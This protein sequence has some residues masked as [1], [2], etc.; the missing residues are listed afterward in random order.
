MLYN[1]DNGDEW[2][3]WHAGLDMSQSN[4]TGLDGAGTWVRIDVGA[5]QTRYTCQSAGLYR[6]NGADNVPGV[7]GFISGTGMPAKGPKAWGTRGAKVPLGIGLVRKGEVDQGVINHAIAWAYHGP[8]PEYVAPAQNSD[9]GNFGGVMGLDLPE[10][11]RIRLNPTFDLTRF[12]AGTARIVGRA[13]QDYGAILVD[14]SGFPKCYLE[15]SN[16]AGWSDVTANMLSAA[17]LSEYQV[18]DWRA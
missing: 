3:I 11:T 5:G 17:S 12:P 15:S 14:N 4:F 9:G 8:S 2:N 10:G 6:V 18:I 13:L 16:S 7:G 1:V